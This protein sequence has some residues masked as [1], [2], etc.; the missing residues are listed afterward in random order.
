M[1]LTD[2]GR[3]VALEVIRHHRLLELFLAETLQMPWD[4]VHDEAEVLEH[5]LSEEL[6]QLIAAQARRPHARP[7]RRPDPE[8]RPAAARARDP[9]PRQPAGAATAASSCASPTPTRRCSATSPSAASLPGDRF[10]VLDRQPFGGPLF[11]SFDG[12]EH[13]IGGLL[14][15]AM[16]VELDGDREGPPRARRGRAPRARRAGRGAAA[17]ALAR[18]APSPLERLLA[19]GRVRATLAMLGPAFVAAVAYVDPGNFATN[20]QGGAQFGYLLLWVVLL[21]NLMAMLIQYLSAKLGIVT[22]HNLPELFRAT[23]PRA[24]SRGACGCRPR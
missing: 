9:Q 5:V 1:R 19:R 15:R 18:S 17:Q 23:L 11:V 6:E 2:K 3:R 12:R 20:I 7:P 14:A 21:A 10:E 13:P 16:R 4:R 24:R 22:D 8:R